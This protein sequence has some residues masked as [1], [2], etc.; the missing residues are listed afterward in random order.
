[1]KMR[2]LRFLLLAILVA[3][4]TGSVAWTWVLAQHVDQLETT[5]KQTAARIDRLDT[6]ID[7][8]ARDELGYVTSGQV[9]KETLTSASSRIRQI[10]SE[11]SW[12]LGQSLAGATPSAGAIAQGV[13]TLAEV[14]ARARENMRADLDLMAADLLFTGTTRTRQTLREQLRT[15]RSAESRAVADA[16]ATDLQ[17]AWMALSAVAL[18]LAWLLVRS[19]R[20]SSTAPATAVTHLA[21]EADQSPVYVLTSESS[22][23]SPGS[24]IDLAQAAALCTAISRLKSEVDLPPLLIR[25]AALLNASGVVVWMAAGD[26][27]FPVAWH[28]YDARQLSQ[29]GPI[30]ASSPNATAAAWRTGT[31]QSVTGGHSSS[32]AIVAPLLGIDRCI[33]ALAIEISSGREADV[34]TQAV[35]TLI[36]AQLVTVIGA[37]PAGTTIPPAEVVPFERVSASN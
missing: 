18:L 17:Q 3:A 19:T 13:A 4:G 7:E 1:M 24:S 16:R 28:G 6:L 14:D 11:S 37:W 29:L 23:E 12:L 33:G 21:P 5:G 9:D 35:A 34:T 2:I 25:T 27:M 31:L 10:V 36:A 30:G 20:W 8:L 32:S 26:E 22:P 15:L